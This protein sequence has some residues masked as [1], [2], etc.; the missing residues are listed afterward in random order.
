M[1][2]INVCGYLEYESGELAVLGLHHTLQGLSGT[3]AGC[4]LN[5]AVKQ[6]LHTEI[7]EGRTK[8]YRCQLTAQILAAVKRLVN[9]VNEFQVGAQFGSLTLTYVSLKVSAVDIDI[10]LLCHLLLIWGKE[11]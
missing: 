4:N 7:V 10:D 9:A 11:V 5:K 8:E 3:R 1:V 6:L 2:G